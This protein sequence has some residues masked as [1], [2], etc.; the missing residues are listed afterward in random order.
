MGQSTETLMEEL[1]F[2]ST[3]RS[4]GFMMVNT[5]SAQHVVNYYLLRMLASLRSDE[6]FRRRVCVPALCFLP[7]FPF[8]GL[9]PLPTVLCT[10]ACP[11]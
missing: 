8:S 7:C 4:M 10:L 3:N 1:Q 9:V 6:A 11:C 2:R 5:S